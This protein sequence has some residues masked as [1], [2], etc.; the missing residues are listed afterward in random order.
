MALARIITRSQTCSRELALDLLARGYTVEIVSPDAIPDNLADLELRVDAGPGDQLV[1]SVETHDGERSASLEFLHHLKAPM[2]DFMRRPPDAREVSHLS[3]AP[4]SFDTEPSAADA[5]EVAA[6]DASEDMQLPAPPE[7]RVEASRRE[8]MTASSAIVVPG[9]FIAYADHEERA[10]ESARLAESPEASSLLLSSSLSLPLSSSS[11]SSSSSSSSSQAN[12]S[13][14]FSAETAAIQDSPVE[15][16]S[17]TVET[18]E[19]PIKPVPVARPV[20][21]H[22]TS[23]WRDRYRSPGWFWRTGLT[24]ASVAA[25]AIALIFG[26]GLGLRPGKSSGQGSAG[27]VAEAAAEKV[28]AASPDR[29]IAVAPNAGKDAVRDTAQNIAH[30]PVKVQPQSLPIASP[31]T[32]PEAS[33]G[34]S[35][36]SLALAK[37]ATAAD[38]VSV[39]VAT[40][41]PRRKSTDDNDLV[42]RD[43]V[44]YLDKNFDH[45]IAKKSSATKSTKTLARHV[46]RTHSHGDGI[47]A[48]NSVTYLNDKPA[49]KPAK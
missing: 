47:V 33:L 45:R 34:N 32:K 1:A 27:I 16:P 3:E 22:P 46:P 40:A 18:L 12:H 26:L 4:V 37:P 2:G 28:S 13:A 39:P 36:K 41:K 23:F 24:L 31:V 19:P 43:T 29:S 11:L 21:L 30:G 25:I 7:F 17:E 8:P 38:I 10:H 15:H 14:S 42:A 6:K 35:P 44:T 49:P 5:A 20:N 9:P 48:A